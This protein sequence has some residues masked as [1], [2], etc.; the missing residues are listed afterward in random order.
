[1]GNHHC[2][3][4]FRQSGLQFVH[5]NIVLRN[6]HIYKHRHCSILNHRGHRSR[7]A[8]GDRNNLISPLNTAFSKKGRRQCHKSSQVRGGAGIYQA[9]VAHAQIICQLPLKGACVPAGGKPKF[10][11]AVHQIHH[12]LMIIYAGSVGNSVP[13]PKRFLLVMVGIAILCHQL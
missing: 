13:L 9:A 3:C 12:L 1:M 2:L 7:E 6:G 10:Q 11:R 8:A 4:L 5:I